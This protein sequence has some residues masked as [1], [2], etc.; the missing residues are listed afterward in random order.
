MHGKMVISAY[1]FEKSRKGPIFKAS[2]QNKD[3]FS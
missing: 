3:T 1:V 2:N